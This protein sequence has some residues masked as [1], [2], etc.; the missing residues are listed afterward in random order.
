MY[1]VI[2]YIKYMYIYRV[3]QQIPD[4]V[5][6]KFPWILSR[7]CWHA[8]CTGCF[9]IFL[10]SKR[11]LL[12]VPFLMLYTLVQLCRFVWKHPVYVYVYIYIYILYIRVLQE[13]QVYVKCCP[14]TL[15]EKFYVW[16]SIWP[17]SSEYKPSLCVYSTVDN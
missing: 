2:L 9:Q 11:R 7:F 14:D 6:S 12:D 16:R 4:K 8:L 15:T 13:S 3:R 10:S 5:P 17:I 1:F